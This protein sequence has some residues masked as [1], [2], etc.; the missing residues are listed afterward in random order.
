MI[1]CGI[2]FDTETGLWPLAQRLGFE[3]TE[4]MLGEILSTLVEDPLLP[5]SYIVLESYFNFFLIKFYQRGLISKEDAMF[6]E[7]KM[8]LPEYKASNVKNFLKYRL[9]LT[10]EFHLLQASSFKIMRGK[11]LKYKTASWIMNEYLENSFVR[12]GIYP[13]NDFDLALFNAEDHS[14]FLAFLDYR[15]MSPNKNSLANAPALSE[16]GEF[17]KNANAQTETMNEDA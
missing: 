3:L 10:T 2:F 14:I 5:S 7:Y 9:K 6:K 1:K 11:F 13:S 12:Q 15:A 4:F 17:T 16:W 8:V